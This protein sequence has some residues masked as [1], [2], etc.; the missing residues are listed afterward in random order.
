MTF[1]IF[2]LLASVYIRAAFCGTHTVIDYDRHCVIRPDG[3]Y[4]CTGHSE[5]FALLDGDECSDLSKVTHGIRK[6]HSKVDVG[7]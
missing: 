2:L 1:S 7:V 3:N 4:G 6:D 5:H